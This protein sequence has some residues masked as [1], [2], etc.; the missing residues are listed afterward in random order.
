MRRIKRPNTDITSLHTQFGRG[1]DGRI[2]KSICL[3]VIL[4]QL[5][6]ALFVL[7]SPA[8]Q[9]QSRSPSAVS[10]L[11]RGN[12]W[13]A[14]GDLDQAIADYT[15]ALTFDPHCAIA[16]YNRGQVRIIQGVLD[17]ALEDFSRAIEL[18]PRLAKAYHNRGTIRYLQG[19][20]D[21]ALAD[22]NSAIQINPRLAKAYHNRGLVRVSWWFPHNRVEKAL[23]FRKYLSPPLISISPSPV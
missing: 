15:I 2:V 11:E 20:L 12:A 18:D 7:T 5:V 4:G 9:A 1:G 21:G 13:Q 16:Y 19:D 22:F 23:S 3:T 8:A 6:M 14:K 17:K 10:Y